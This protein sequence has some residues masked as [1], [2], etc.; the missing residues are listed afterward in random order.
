MRTQKK[1]KKSIDRNL[2]QIRGC[3]FSPHVKMVD[4]KTLAEVKITCK[5]WV[6]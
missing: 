2:D 1:E 4:V 6:L 3:S 5:C